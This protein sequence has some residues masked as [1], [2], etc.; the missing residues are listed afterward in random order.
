MPKVFIKDYA[1]FLQDLQVRIDLAVGAV[2][3]SN[4]LHNVIAPALLKDF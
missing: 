1:F 4:Q 3:F 2:D